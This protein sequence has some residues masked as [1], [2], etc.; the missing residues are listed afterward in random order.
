M[1]KV[2]L[3]FKPE[4]SARIIAQRVATLSG[5]ETAAANLFLCEDALEG[6]RDMEAHGSVYI[7]H[8]IHARRV[9]V[10]ALLVYRETLLDRLEKDET[11]RARST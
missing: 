8:S 3:A 5:Q 7:R 10:E 2:K 4:E 9:I 11:E 1:A 6:F